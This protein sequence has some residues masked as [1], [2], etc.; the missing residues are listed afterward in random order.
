MASMVR[1]ILIIADIE[2]SSGCWS[3]RDAAFLNREWA[4]ACDGMSADVAAVANALIRICDLTPGIEKR[5]G[6]FLPLFNARGRMGMVWLRWQL[7]K[8]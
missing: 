1:H 4:Q 3:R 6:W 7:R 5:F 8:H 2:G